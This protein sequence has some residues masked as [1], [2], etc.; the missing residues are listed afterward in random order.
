M[1][2]CVDTY[3]VRL[4]NPPLAR[5]SLERVAS[6]VLPQLRALQGRH[7]AVAAESP[8]PSHE[9]AGEGGGWVG[10]QCSR[11]CSMLTPITLAPTQLTSKRHASLP[12]VEWWRPIPCI[13]VLGQRHRVIQQ[14]TNH[15]CMWV[16]GHGHCMLQQPTPRACTESRNRLTKQGARPAVEA[17]FGDVDDVHDWVVSSLDSVYDRL[18]DA[19]AAANLALQQKQEQPSQ[20]GA[21]LPAAFPPS[22]PGDSR[23]FSA[24]GPFKSYMQSELQERPQD[25]FEPRVNNSNE[26]FRPQ[27]DHLAEVM[28][29]ED[30]AAVAGNALVERGWG[31]HWRCV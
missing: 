24:P 12:I 17:A 20:G 16:L 19:V 22:A 23:R 13:G 14:P 8:A 26:P 30:K 21:S 1:H 18:D 2:A 31:Q 28:H 15:T 5:H 25:A 11:G 3:A 10:A 27:L 29:P 6:A 4:I 7:R 9:T